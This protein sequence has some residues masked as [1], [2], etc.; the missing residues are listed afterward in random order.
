MKIGILIISLMLIIM[1]CTNKKNLTGTQGQEGPEPVET[2]VTSNM[3]TQFY[4]FEDSTRNFNSDN[5]LLGNYQ[6]NDFANNAVTLL[7]FTSLV[8]TFYQVLNVE[9]KMQIKEKH[10]NHLIRSANL[11]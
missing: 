9:L 6:R 10:I 3:F 2:E 8:D 1:G 11:T 4:S 5:L 7:K